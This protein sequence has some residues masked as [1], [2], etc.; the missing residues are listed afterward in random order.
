MYRA[1]EYTLNPVSFSNPTSPIPYILSLSKIFLHPLFLLISL[2]QLPISYISP[3]PRSSPSLSSAR[4]LKLFQTVE[5]QPIKRNVNTLALIAQVEADA[6]RK[7]RRQKA[8]KVTP[9]L[10]TYVYYM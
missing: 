9:R 5:E 4:N 2:V 1:L 3:S 6:T 10:F 8:A 7:K